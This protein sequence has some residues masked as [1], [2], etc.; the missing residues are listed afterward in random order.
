MKIL[1]I[2][3]KQENLDAAK[4]QLAGH[5]LTTASS[6]DEAEKYLAANLCSDRNY[7]RWR[8]NSEIDYIE[9]KFDVIL[10]DLFLPASTNA[11]VG[12]KFSDEVPYGT[13]LA[14][15][16][17]RLGIPVAIV[18]TGGHHA[19]S[20]MWSLDLLDLQSR[21]DEFNPCLVGNTRFLCFNSGTRVEDG[22][23]GY[24]IV[25]DWDQALERLL[26]K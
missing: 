25:K 10:T 18:T 5:E 1:I 7:G 6:Y 23:G 9:S 15:A 3:D 19:N 4:K 20:F 8:K 11:V 17:L 22:K 24:V 2:D 21:D 13:V 16:A 14:L 12:V 26:R